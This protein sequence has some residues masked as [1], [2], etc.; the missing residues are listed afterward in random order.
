ME[1]VDVPPRRSDDYNAVVFVRVN[2]RTILPPPS[3]VGAGAPSRQ[4]PVRR[5]VLAYDLERDRVRIS[6]GYVYL[7][8]T[9]WPPD[10]MDSSMAAAAYR[11]ACEELAAVVVRDL[12]KQRIGV[13]PAP[14]AAR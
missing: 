5:V 2:V 4:S 13:T 9:E 6:S 8:V 10:R 1:D 7:N 12:M 14:I 3:P 11:E